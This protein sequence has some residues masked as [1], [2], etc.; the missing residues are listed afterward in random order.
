MFNFETELV[1]SI[2]KRCT[3]LRSNSSFRQD[4][5]ADKSAISK[6]EN[7]KYNE[8]DNLHNSYSSRGLRNNF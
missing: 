8:G 6:I 1:E 5:I 7:M 2:S 4:D 3:D